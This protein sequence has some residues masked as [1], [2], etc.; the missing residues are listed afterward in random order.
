MRPGSCHCRVGR[1]Q[2]E[3]TASVPLGPC[4]LGADPSPVAGQAHLG[5]RVLGLW[6]V[7]GPATWLV[8]RV[9]LLPSYKRTQETLSQAGQKTSAALSTVG[10]AIS[11]K[12]GDVRCD[13]PARPR[14][15]CP[16]AWPRGAG[17]LGSCGEPDG[18]AGCRCPRLGGPRHHGPGHT[19]L[20][21]PAHGSARV[22][23]VAPLAPAAP[24]LSSGGT[25]TGAS[26]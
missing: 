21:P 20:A 15:L 9:F 23:C 26:G 12:L 14:P 13:V 16:E 3:S 8:R 10:S 24:F 7:A 22:A 2:P 4:S 1:P 17:H 6:A 19:I 25:V 18:A 5:H 11:R